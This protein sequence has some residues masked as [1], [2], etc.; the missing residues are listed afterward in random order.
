[1]SDEENV[2]RSNAMFGFNFHE[3][4]NK[5]KDALFKEVENKSVWNDELL[6]EIRILN[7]NIGIIANALV[8]NP[9]GPGAEAA[10]SH[11]KK[12]LD[13]V[14]VRKP[15]AFFVFPPN[16]DSD[17]VG[18]SLPNAD[19]DVVGCSLPNVNFDVPDGPNPF[20]EQNNSAERRKR[21]K[22]NSEEPVHHIP[23]RRKDTAERLNNIV[24]AY[25]RKCQRNAPEKYPH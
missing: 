22:K 13:E 11:F 4:F 25:K 5:I 21:K 17:V 7:L 23:E 14:S 15:N 19:S 24:R 8:Y 10:K 2:A 12:K 20:D 6:K 1:M 16:Y 9:D 18:G 3:E